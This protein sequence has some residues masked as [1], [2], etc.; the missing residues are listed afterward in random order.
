MWLVPH[1]VAHVV[2]ARHRMGYARTRRTGPRLATAALASEVSATTPGTRK[3]R[4]APRAAP[5]TLS[6]ATRRGVGAAWL[7]N[8]RAPSLARS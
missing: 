7:T 5:G 1:E 6:A 2:H 4:D 3:A 8:V